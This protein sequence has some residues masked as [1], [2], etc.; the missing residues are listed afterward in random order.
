MKTITEQFIRTL[1]A[2]LKSAQI[3]TNSYELELYSFDGL[4][5]HKAIPG[6]VVLPESTEEI[7]WIVKQ[8]NKFK[9]PFVPRGAGTGLSGG[10]V[11]SEGLIIQLSRL[12]KILDIDI[13]NKCAI[14]QPGVV[15]AHL[16]QEVNTFGLHFAP[17]PSSQIAS[18]IGGNVAGVAN[19]YEKHIWRVTQRGHQFKRSGLLAFNPVG[20]YRVHQGNVVAISELSAQTQG[21][22]KVSVNHDDFGAVDHCLGQLAHGHFAFGNQ[23]KGRNIAVSAKCGR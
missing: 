21:D 6:C 5:L 7:S 18:T 16:S 2:N 12:N 20:V 15:N 22:V 10:A 9:I 1:N 4:Q 19:G 17:D 23:H 11:I 13:P 8:C 14:V 3:R